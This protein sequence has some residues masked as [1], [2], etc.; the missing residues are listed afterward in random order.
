M[1]KGW[2]GG[3]TRQWR[4]TRAAVLEQNQLDTGGRCTVQIPTICTR[5]ADTV[6][7]TKGRAITGDDPAHL[8]ASCTPCNL[9]IGDPQTHNPACPLCAQRPSNALDPEPRPMTW[10]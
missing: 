1:S 5:W 3:S 8:V 10:W 2:T 7:H 4:R 6:H 9:H